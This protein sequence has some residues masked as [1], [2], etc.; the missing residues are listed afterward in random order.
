MTTSLSDYE[1]KLVSDA[2]ILLTKNK[3]IQKVYE[4]LGGIAEGYK[5]EF[6][7][8]GL[9]YINETDA[10]ISRGENYKGLPYVILDYPRVF[11]K[12]NVFA[13]RTFFWWGNF[14]SITLQLSGIYKENYSLKIEEAIKEDLFKGWFIGCAPEPWEHHFEKD[15]YTPI[16]PTGNTFA[17]NLSYIK[18]SKKIPLE[19]WDEV[20]SFFKENF[21]FLIKILST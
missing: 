12:E 11:G 4:L 21:T 20:E 17:S 1:L 9:N 13:I 7:S 3:I 14:F 8:A 18:I 16:E 10:K 15:N 2:D 5:K 6:Q 19:K